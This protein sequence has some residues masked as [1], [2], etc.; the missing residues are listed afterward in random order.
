[1][2]PSGWIIPLPIA[3]PNLAWALLPSPP[4]S[5]SGSGARESEPRFLLFLERAGRI[6]IFVLPFFLHVHVSTTTDRLCLGVAVLALGI[7]Y[8][9]WARYFIRGRLP[10]LLY[11][12]FT[13]I[14]V[15]LAIAPVTYFLAC[16]GPARSFALAL[17]TL[18]FG[19]AH[20]SLSVRRARST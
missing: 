17:V 8:L 13:G 10:E 5:G 19:A 3:L 15:P 1:V 9:G 11:R 6:A 20:I 7:Y 4:V 18:A 16:S 12:P 2:I 14:P